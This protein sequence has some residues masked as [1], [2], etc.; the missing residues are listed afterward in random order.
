MHSTVSEA[1]AV[2]A[3][4]CGVAMQHTVSCRKLLMRKKSAPLRSLRSSFRRSV[5]NDKSPGGAG[6]AALAE[7][8]DALALSTGVSRASSGTRMESRLS[9]RPS[10]LLQ[11]GTGS[12]AHHEPGLLVT[13]ERSW[14]VIDTADAM[15]LDGE[16]DVAGGKD[17]ATGGA[18]TSNQGERRRLASRELARAL[19]ASA[20]TQPSQQQQEGEG[21]GEAARALSGATNASNEK[22]MKALF[23]NHS[24]RGIDVSHFSSGNHCFMES[25]ANLPSRFS[26]DDDMLHSSNSAGGHGGGACLTELQYKYGGFSILGGS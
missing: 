2:L 11:S 3:E 17:G 18:E 14:G 16:E 25:D 7:T 24:V 22:L 5:S 10:R 8:S 20:S 4:A 21:S 19:A 26:I 23:V 6:A 9:R 12:A 1:E 13:S 15:P